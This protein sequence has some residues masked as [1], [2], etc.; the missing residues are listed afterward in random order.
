MAGLSFEI[1]GD[2]T[3]L[4]R[5]LE[6]TE[7]A[8]KNT[9]KSIEREGGSIDNLFGRLTKAA[10]AFSAGLSV[11]EIGQSIIKVRGEFQ[12]LEVAFTTMLGSK[13][14]ADRL[15]S[16]MVETAAT[17]PFDLQSVANGA[18]QL[19]AYGTA[20]DD[21]NETL[22]RLGN[23]AA[24]L[25]IPLNDLVYLYGTTMTQGRL[26]TEDLNQFTGRGIP[27]IRE[28][29]EVLGVAED[30][31]KGLV[32][33]GRVGFPEVQKVI[34]NLTNEGG[35]FFNLMSEQSKT[36]TGQIS[37]IGDSFSQ[38]FNEIGKQ[39]EGIINEA[40]SGISYLVENYESVG[41]AI[42]EMAAS[43]GAYKA[44]LITITGLQKAYSVVLQQSIVEKNLAAAAG[45]TLSNAEALAAS[46]TKLLQ[47]AQAALNKTMLANPYVLAAAAVT[48][49][50]YGI[51]KLVTYQT[52]FEKG[53][54]RLNNA[55]NE[56]SKASLSEQRE[57][58][59]LKGE[60]SSLTK[61]TNEYNEVKN[62]IVK[63]YSKYY[64]GLEKEIDKVGLTEEAYKK[65]TTAI[66][67]SYGA[68]QYEKFKIEQQGELDEVMSKNLGKIQDRLIDQL[69]EEAGARYYAK[70]RDA[71]LQGNIAVGKTNTGAY[72]IKGLDS[73]TMSVLDKVAG[74][75]GGLFDITNRA[76]EG[77]ISNIVN[78]INLTEKLD[79]EAKER[80]GVNGS[81]SNIA[82]GAGKENNDSEK[83]NKNL[84]Q[85]IQSIQE[86]EKNLASLRL[87]SQ[88]GLIDTSE[89]ESAEKELKGLKDTFA[90]MTGKE[91]GKEDK[92]LK[93]EIKKRK[94]LAEELIQVRLQ[95][96][97]DEI[98]LMEDGAEKRMRQLELDYQKEYAEISALRNKW[99]EA[100]GGTLTQEQSI[101]I[102]TRYSNAE[103]KYNAGLSLIDKEQADEES[104]AMNDYLLEYGTFQQ[105]K[106][107][108]AIKYSNLI[109]EA[110]TEGEKLS[111]GKE[112]DKELTD[113][114]IKAGNTSNA[115]ISLFGDMSNKS[116]AELEELAAR[117]QE[118]L[119]F[120]Q[121]GEWD[122]ATG[123]K[124]GITEDEFRRWQESPELIKQ[125][126]DAI[127]EVKG[128]SDALQP[129]FVKVSDGIKQFFNSGNDAK[130]LQDALSLINEGVNE[131]MSSVGFLSDVFGTLGDSFGGAF[132]GIAEGMGVSMD[133]VNAGLQGMQAG[134]MF[135]P[136][137]ASAGAAIGV[138]TSLASAIAKIHDKK[139]EQRIQRLQDQIDVLDSSY[140]NLGRSIEK[141]YS[142]DASKLIDQQNEL[143]E[144]QKLLIQQQIM[145]EEDKKKT[146]DERIK[147]WKQQIEDIDNQIKDNAEQAQEAIA[148]I[149][150]DTFRNNF[151]ETLSDF[152][153]TAEDFAEDFEGYL[154]SA[155]L[156]SLLASKYDKKIK[157]L[158]NRWTELGEDGLSQSEIEKLRAEQQ[159][160]VEQML[161]D[162]DNL[163]SIF[164]WGGSEEG[165]SSNPQ[166]A[167][168]GG[169]EGMSQDQASELNGR[170]SAL[171][172]SGEEIKRSMI[173]VL[174]NINLLI[175]SMDEMTVVVS[176]I[177]DMVRISTSHLEDISTYSKKILDGFGKKLDEMNNTLKM[178][179]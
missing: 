25:S 32:T 142:T 120:I 76:V 59:R 113:L 137:G 10:A 119:E 99:Q 52:E 38:M 135:G 164:G 104:R 127:K 130:K 173:Q 7:R 124:L 30:E 29:S 53:Q 90:T 133:A 123:M 35:M 153:S 94:E 33:E 91:Y 45:I 80:F 20:A 50:G 16:Q 136:I 79:N 72:D 177:R 151:L 18:R 3:D 55:L 97:Q 122:A 2:N 86:A 84:Q 163:A 24:G 138:V 100:N 108:L 168:T 116:L 61:G 21:V 27:M 125:A 150:F 172:M 159:A 152:D 47:T 165:T 82:T 49:L 68:R 43:Y 144:Q 93:E 54:D 161:S 44:I 126:G 166:E 154:Q 58:A 176:E 1:V 69:G 56:S 179:I 6:E 62:K 48:A 131:I 37:N 129:S 11:K 155:I 85:I 46:R 169:F 9:S 143:L 140:N 117:G 83:E 109:A 57:L 158:Y 178:A 132:S 13:E 74:K 42:V 114:E 14:A 106:A 96:Q 34:Q 128:Q 121:G 112:W 8:I 28:L 160:I 31:V 92:S 23:I 26:Y 101:E 64:D 22:V 17:T 39:N 103:Q 15:M 66:T 60:L 63:G 174:T 139:N 67:Q 12:Q 157:Q 70:I 162:R 149:S 77:Y 88:K 98:N 89:V 71:I 175:V 171:Q 167:S 4:M 75:E 170:F 111:L 51:Y 105:K 141:A 40:L 36:I 134:S 19:I 95:N 145:E 156:N 81:T 107:A 87:Q 41:K 110:T 5:K 78:A 148:G 102:N 73:D 147:Q 65:L 118:A 146:D 115:I